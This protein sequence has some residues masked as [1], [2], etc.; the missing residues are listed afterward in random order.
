LEIESFDREIIAYRAIGVGRP[1]VL[2]HGFLSSAQQT[3]MQ[4]GLATQLAAS[5]RRVIL[6]DFRGHG[7]S[8]K[9]QDPA[10]Y[11][12]DVL[13]MDVE[14][15]LQQMDITDCDVAGYSLGAR[16]AARMVARG[17]RPRKLALCGM[18]FEGLTAIAARQAH[19][20]NLIVNGEASGN[21]RAARVVAAMME[22]TGISATAALAVLR[23]QRDVTPEELALFEA[24][25]R[26]VCGTRDRDNGDPALLAAAI[27]GA[28]L[29]QP[30]GDHLSTVSAPAFADALVRFFGEAA[31]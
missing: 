24:E 21:P 31:A 6:P 23:S 7:R 2:L 9:P 1:L 4:S 25:T 22:Q 13:A 16:I 10:R 14:A 11:P 29:E 28:A 17:L 15:L 19:F 8:A 20:E 30:D 3:W 5:R 12:A 18:G 27:P 26:I